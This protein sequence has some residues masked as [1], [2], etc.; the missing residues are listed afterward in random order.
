MLQPV[1]CL[2][3]KHRLN[4]EPSFSL[5]IEMASGSWALPLSPRVSDGLLGHGG[6]IVA[7]WVELGGAV[8][9]R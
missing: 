8:R 3:D 7:V 2:Y 9:L 6:V 1:F 4:P 5:S